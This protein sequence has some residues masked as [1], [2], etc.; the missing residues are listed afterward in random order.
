MTAKT[1]CIFRDCR[2]EDL[3]LL[4]K[5]V[6]SMYEEDKTA[7]SGTPQ[8]RLSYAELTSKPD[9]GRLLV[10]EQNGKTCGYAILIFFWSNEFCGNI[11]DIDELYI[12][13]AQRGQGIARDFFA[14][15]AHEY[16]N[17][18]SGWSLQVSDQNHR[19]RK[20]YESLGFC[21]SPNQHMI[22]VFN[23]FDIQT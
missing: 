12:E 21:S 9:K 2:V 15:L 20:L 18:S 7:H 17:N 14:W 10:I 1:N 5:F 23:R 22:K 6:D 13:P 19:A 3:E 11:I 4:E 16:K 8:I